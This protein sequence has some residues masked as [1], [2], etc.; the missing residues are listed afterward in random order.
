[1]LALAMD[2]VEEGRDFL[3]FLAHFSIDTGM[4]GIYVDVNNKLVFELIL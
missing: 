4:M 3:I 2:K 1:M